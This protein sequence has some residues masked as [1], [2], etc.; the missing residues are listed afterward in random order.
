MK[1]NWDYLAG[2]TDG[3][4]SIGIVGRGPR[5]TWGQKDRNVLNEV[6]LFIESQGIR[7]NFNI[8][9]AN[10][11]SRRPNDIY[12]LTVGYRDGVIRLI[13]ELRDRL[14]LKVFQCDAVEKWIAEHPSQANRA[15]IDIDRVREL[16]SQGYTQGAIGAMLNCSDQKVRKYAKFSGIK[17]DGSGKVVDGKWVNAMTRAELMEHRSKK[18]KTGKCVDCSKAIY[19][20]GERCISCAMKYRHQTKP[21][22]FRA[23]S[24]KSAQPA[25]SQSRELEKQ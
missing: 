9:S 11:A 24:T 22:S 6:R 15:D 14:I 4:G 19:P 23:S 25:I 1:V 12:M 13:S 20:K 16:A 17:F 18:E 3:E 7:T 10:P 5:I 2:F 8:I 21:E